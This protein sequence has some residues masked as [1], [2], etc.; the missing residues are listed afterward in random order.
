MDNRDFYNFLTVDMPIE[1]A[2]LFFIKYKYGGVRKFCDL[3]GVSHQG[4]Y[5]AIA[6]EF[7]NVRSKIAEVFGFDPW[8]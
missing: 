6:G 8:K 7:P 3:I 1:K 4:V 5:G 2:I